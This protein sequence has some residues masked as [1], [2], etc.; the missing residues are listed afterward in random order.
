M[1]EAFVETDGMLRD[2]VD[3]MNVPLHIV[4]GPIP[5][6]PWYPL[7]HHLS[8]PEI[9]VVLGKIAKRHQLSERDILACGEDPRTR[10]LL[11]S[12]L[13]NE[14]LRKQPPVEYTAALGRLGGRNARRVLT[15]QFDR[16]NEF[17]TTSS[18]FEARILATTTAVLRMRPRH[19]EATSL[20][21]EAIDS[22][23]YMAIEEAVRLLASKTSVSSK[24]RR[25]LLAMNTKEDDDAF[26]SALPILL[27]D[28]PDE[29][30]IR[31]LALLSD[32]PRE[33]KCGIVTQLLCMDWVK[34]C[35]LQPFLRDWLADVPDVRILLECAWPMSIAPCE[36]QSLLCEALGAASP[37]LRF[38]AL[39]RL[40]EV[41]TQL[42]VFLVETALLDEP[43]PHLR[44]SLESART[45]FGYNANSTS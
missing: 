29:S 28:R 14:H 10:G 15:E 16:R 8:K 9:E 11:V 34:D 13:Q 43:D 26:L 41:E 19:R 38:S 33:G 25:R 42:A 17:A 1:K 31:L 30:R 39:C 6:V 7:H 18:H 21:L 45:V 44:L 32:T 20:L 5:T 4:R 36:P 35:P 23:V 12:A 37:W 22:G 2:A 40:C 3:G 27:Q 24:L